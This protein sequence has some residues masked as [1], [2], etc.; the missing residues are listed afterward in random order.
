MWM[1]NK[2]FVITVLSH[3]LIG[4]PNKLFVAVIGTFSPTNGYMTQ[5]RFRYLRTGVVYGKVCPN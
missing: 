5:Q 1:P 4:K 3:F 2:K